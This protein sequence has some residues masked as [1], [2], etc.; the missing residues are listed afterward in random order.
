MAKK[1][2]G[3]LRWLF[4][5]NTILLAVAGFL[6]CAGFLFLWAA[7][8]KIP[9]LQTFDERKVEQ[10]T[11][12]YD[13]TGEILLFDIHENTQRTVVPFS[14]ISRHIKNATVA[15]EDSEF[16]THHGIKPTA[17]L[18]AILVN[19][20]SFGYTQGGSTITQQVVKNSIDRKS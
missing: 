2:R 12:I 7:T 11:K 19:I 1:H 20:G 17:I 18:R 10:S 6:F 9:D 14:D 8:L 4:K 15:I 3:L 16:Y 13:R 5:K